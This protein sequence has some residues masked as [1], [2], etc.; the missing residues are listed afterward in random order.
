MKLIIITGS[1]QIDFRPSTVS[2][3]YIGCNFS[4]FIKNY[5]FNV[6]HC[7]IHK[8]SLSCSIAATADETVLV[9]KATLNHAIGVSYFDFILKKQ[10]TYPDPF[11]IS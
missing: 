3:R 7:R 8:Y 2:A 11:K 1:L 5:G 9:F 10:S 6:I 4:I